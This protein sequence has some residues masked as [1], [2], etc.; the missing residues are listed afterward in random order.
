[1]NA[2]DYRATP[3][4]AEPEDKDGLGSGAS[5]PRMSHGVVRRRLHIVATT[6]A[7]IGA[8]LFLLGVILHPGRDGASIA[9]VGDW[10]G[11]THGVE[12]MGLV[13]VAIGLIGF[14]ALA[15][16]R[17]GTTG[18]VAFLTA[19]AGTVLWF[20]LIAVD[21]TRN[22][23]TARYAPAIVHTTADLDPGA[24]IVSVPALLLFP[25]GYALLALVLAR[26]GMRWPGL[27]IGAG[28]VVY[29][30][31]AIPL[32]VL[33]PLSSAPQILEIAGALPYT[34]GFILLARWWGES[35]ESARVQWPA[36]AFE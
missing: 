8:S 19:V 1:M 25:I 7:V 28:A 10:Y 20:G 27:L 35:R 13:L 32:A 4:E 3:V 9:A 29:W 5:A 16:D 2:M 31:A 23:V 14:Y 6:A 36:E 22:P 30:S 24:A 21:G 18:L 12:A 17:L 34:L 11:V 26:R 33:G 15:A